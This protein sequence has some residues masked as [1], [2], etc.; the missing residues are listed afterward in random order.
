MNF[1][2]TTNIELAEILLSVFN[3]FVYTSKINNPELIQKVTEKLRNRE[4]IFEESNKLKLPR[5]SNL[6][7]IA[8]LQTTTTEFPTNTNPMIDS[9]C[10]D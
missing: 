1:S 8:T 6:D 10:D 9:I 3:I 4:H 5:T 2:K 7:D